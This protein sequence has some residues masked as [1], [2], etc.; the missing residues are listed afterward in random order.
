MNWGVLDR[1]AKSLIKEAGQH[2]KHSFSTEIVVSSKSS[3]N[4]LVTNIDREIEQFF[5]KRIHR[6]FP[7][8]R[9]MGEEGFGDDIQSLDGVIWF[10]DP[11]DGTMNFV[12]QKRN[13]AIS[14]GIYIDGI[15]MLGYVY[16]VMA[17]DLY[18][19]MKDEGA[20][21]NDIRLPK[22]MDTTIEEAIVGVNASW[23]APNRYVDHDPIID[24]VN[25]CRGTRSYGSAA[26]E[27][28]HVATGR[29]DVYMS[30]RLSPWDVAGG[31]II[32]NEVGAISSTMSGQQPGMLQSETFMV[33]NAS[34]HT[35]LLEE[36]I[37]LKK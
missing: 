6:D 18:S 8:H 33:A 23:V 1:Y 20:Y 11:I 10:L 9:I 2:I 37:V 22:L 14:L 35:Q 29:V 27:L 30:M 7:N 17:D 28:I 13:F 24:L 32:A 19:A 12:H 5:I 25:K 31:M 3:A 26:L 34:V 4:D 16:D 15:G 36:F 21:L